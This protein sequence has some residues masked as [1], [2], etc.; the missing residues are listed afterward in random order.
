MEDLKGYDEWKIFSGNP[1]ER[2]ADCETCGDTKEC[3]DCNG[4]GFDRGVFDD[5][6]E[7][8]YGEGVCI[9]CGEI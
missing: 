8:C 3:E 2:D 6:C 5:P 9:E 4:T 7:T 1:Y